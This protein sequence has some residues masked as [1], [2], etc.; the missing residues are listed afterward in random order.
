LSLKNPPVSVNLDRRAGYSWA[1][2]RGRIHRLAGVVEEGIEVDSIHLT[3]AVAI[4][5][6]KQ[7][8]GS[9]EDPMLAPVGMASEVGLK[10]VM[11]FFRNFGQ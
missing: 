3:T 9:A 7:R 5:H 8:Q 11:E 4:L 1:G 2:L 10:G 6:Q